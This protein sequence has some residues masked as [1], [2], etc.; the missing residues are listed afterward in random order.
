MTATWVGADGE[1][2]G[3]GFFFL[4]SRFSYFNTTTI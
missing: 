1:L 2:M 3:D 4:F